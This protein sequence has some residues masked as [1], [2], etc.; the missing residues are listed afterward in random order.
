M[1][2][3][4]MGIMRVENAQGEV[5]WSPEPVR[6]P[7]LSAEESWLMVDMLKDVVRR[8][9]AA[10]TVGAQFPYPAG[11]KT[12]TTND[13]TDVWYIGF[14]TDL[15]AGT[16][17][18]LDKPDKIKSN[19]QGGLLAAPAWTAF[20]T[21]VYRRKPPPP[22][23]PRPAGIVS[24]T[25]DLLTNTM[26]AP[27]C[28]GIEATEFFIAGTEPVVP[29]M[30]PGL[31]PDTGAYSSYPPGSTP[32]GGFSPSPNGPPFPRD[33]NLSSMPPS[34]TGGR[35]VPGNASPIRPTQPRDT[36]G[37]GLTRPQPIAPPPVRD[38][39]LARRDSLRARVD[40]IL[41]TPRV[42]TAARRDT[43]A[44]PQGRRRPTR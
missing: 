22:D 33:T 40:S 6:V 26:W 38:T 44:M 42:D 4:A 5:L 2:A 7:T 3:R 19:A 39:A 13:G 15:L 23:W 16:W 37:L 31:Y 35:V 25:V 41:R 14:T 9:T 18:G 1:Q 29:C 17:I 21:E 10:G 32:P 30:G 11:G 27:G 8:G 43:L 36:A 34:P 28:P 24:K 12:G 20:M